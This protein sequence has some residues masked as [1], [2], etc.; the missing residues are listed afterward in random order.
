MTSGLQ[1]LTVN[2]LSLLVA[3][4]S[5]SCLGYASCLGP[6]SASHLLLQITSGFLS[7]LQLCRHLHF[8]IRN[9]ELLFFL[10]LMLVHP[11]RQLLI[12]LITTG[13][14]CRER[15]SSGEA[16]SDRLQMVMD[17]TIAIS[18][19][20]FCLSCSCKLVL[21]LMFCFSMFSSI[22][23]WVNSVTTE[24][25]GQSSSGMPRQPGHLPHLSCTEE[26][27][28]N[29]VQLVSLPQTE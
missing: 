19:R 20:C 29:R 4:D 3:S 17:Y 25:F 26:P 18:T 28:V 23:A 27:R 10:H 5:C 21:T 15:F 2:V 24:L 7:D 22:H 12:L 13:E 14:R 8:F 9:H 1:L 11:Q 6:S 16:T